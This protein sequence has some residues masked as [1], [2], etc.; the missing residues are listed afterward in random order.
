M[1]DFLTQKFST[2]FSSLTGSKNIT[3]QAIDQSLQEVKQVLLQADV[4]LETVDTF[5]KTIQSDVVGRKVTSNIKPAEQF[6][7][8]VHDAMVTFLGGQAVE[9]DR[10]WG[11]KEIVLFMGLQGAGKTTT[12][13]KIGYYLQHGNAFK[14]NRY[15]KLKILCA[16]VDFYRPAAIDQLAIVAQN[17]G[18]DF[19]R[20]QNTDP[21]AAARE[22]VS[23]YQQQAYDYLLLDTAGRLQQDEVLMQELAAI[24]KDIRPTKSFLVLDVMTGQQSLHIAQ[25]FVHKV[26]FDAAIFSKMDSQVPGGSIFAF[27][28]AV[29][30]PVLF[31]GVGEKVDQLEYFRPERIVKRLLGMGDIL[32]LVEQ[33][34]QKIQQSEQEAV[35]KAIMS[36]KM[37]LD[38][39]A[40]QLSMMSRLGSLS[41]LMKLMPGMGQFSLSAQ[42]IDESEKE[43]KKFKA[44]LGSMTLKERQ[45]PDILNAS[46]K[47]RIA[48][49]AGVDIL[50]INQ[51]LQRFEQ[52]KQFVKLLSNNRFFR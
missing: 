35:T 37:T 15:P 45:K 2:I 18:I 52:S 16:S 42:Q 44:I 21:V 31:V 7:K 29:Q 22:I 33:A 23:Y 19:Y 36:G 38:D 9:A 40:K 25:N 51:L 30:K 28:Y 5:M 50:S 27:K 11:N 43:L 1:F 41:S 13:G 48:Q 8:A 17:A 3:P 6:M 24:K 20:A 10:Y 47:T 39:F 26:G 12:I 4:P 32:T 49:G 34:E 14:K 46:R